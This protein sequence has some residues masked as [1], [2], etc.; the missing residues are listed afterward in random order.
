MKFKQSFVAVAFALGFAFTTQAASFTP[1]TYTASA[2][3]MKGPVTVTV[4]LSANRIE[5][6][7]VG[8]NHET[9][10]IG[11]VAI[12][13]L[14]KAIVSK[15]SLKVDKVSGASL[16][17]KALL[18]AVTDCVR[19]AGGD[20]EA[21]KSSAQKTKAIAPKN[22]SA[23]IIVIGGGAAGMSAAV[24]SADHGANVVIVE[25]MPFMGGA[26]ALCGGQYA[27]QGSQLQKAKGVAYDPPQ[28]LVYDLIGNG[29]N[30]NDLTTLKVQAE[31]SPAAADWAIK[32]FN[33]K[34]KDQKLQYRAEFQYDRSLYLEGGCG[35][36]AEQLRQAVKADKIRVYTDT[37]AEKLLMKNG[38][39]IGVEAKNADGTTYRLTGK[40]VLLSTGGYGANKDMLVEPLK[41]A[42]FYGPVSATGDGHRMAQAIG[43]PLQLMQFGK[44]YPNGVE[45]APGVAKSIIQGNY[46]AWL[47]SGILVNSEGKRLINE[48][49]SNN[50]I[51]QVLE[52]QP[53]QMLYLVMDQK[54][55]D[56][57][58]SGVYT[59]GIT[60]QDLEKW[61]AL[62][63]KS[64]PIFAHGKTLDE[65]AAHAGV[66]AAELKKTVARYNELVK[67]G[68][69]EDFGRPTAFMKATISEEGP[70]YIVEQKPRFATTMGSLV[71]NE[72]L[73]V[74]NKSGKV[75]P[76]LYAAG[77]I[78][79]AV[80]G[81]DSSPGMN[82]SWAFTSGKTVSESMLKAVGK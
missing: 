3:G 15:Q 78:I 59:L 57:F 80:H 70:F 22:I 29:H 41:S 43:A 62:N 53:G 35:P 81:D 63:G 11:S 4:K 28:A 82:I 55:W 77:E 73:Q 51:M 67:L 10:G 42:L 12:E 38:R 74:L 45:A 30:Y 18:T 79:N 2:Q 23:D 16:T 7:T 75:I 44:R 21:L 48:K 76:G 71:V 72:K 32:R 58:K 31:K 40:A 27:I 13:R 36:M 33:L 5:S 9:Q 20:P 65:A 17:S 61:L 47:Q 60:D 25:K 46:R 50:N 34:F 69:D 6:V 49:A 19:Q 68:K 52:K 54:T 1:G 37:K 8:A 26:S 66:N 24:N 64:A 39:V 14:P 56:A